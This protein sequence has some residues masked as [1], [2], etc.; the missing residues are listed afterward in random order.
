[1]SA[2]LAPE[3]A[4]VAVDVS[5]VNLLERS[6]EWPVNEGHATCGRSGCSRI[7]LVHESGK[8]L[9]ITDFVVFTQLNV[10]RQGVRL[11]RKLLLDVFA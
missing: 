8:D 1:M 10:G 7:Q 4:V 11:Q 6:D 3:R 5:G 9:V 2:A